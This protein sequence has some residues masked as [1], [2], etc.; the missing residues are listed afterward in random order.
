MRAAI[1]PGALQFEVQDIDTPEPR[2]G[3][4]LV[5]VS[6]SAICGTDAHAFM[7]D[8]AQGHR[9]L[10]R[11]AGRGD[12]A[13]TCLPPH[14]SLKGRATSGASAISLRYNKQHGHDGAALAP[15]AP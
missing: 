3:Q 4:V 9:G 1:C 14:P 8:L 6:R 7:Y 10:G 12:Q 5:Q 15:A 2:S 13:V 11:R